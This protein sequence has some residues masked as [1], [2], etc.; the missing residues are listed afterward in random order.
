VSVEKCVA[1]GMMRP[2]RTAKSLVEPLRGE[3]L[4]RAALSR[5]RY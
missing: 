1:P 3:L 2:G 4:Q 5:D